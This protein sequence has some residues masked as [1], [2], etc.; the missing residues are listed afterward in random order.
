MV[1]YPLF[2]QGCRYWE[3]SDDCCL[4]LQAII[5]WKWKGQQADIG[6]IGSMKEHEGQALL[7]ELEREEAT[8]GSKA[9]LD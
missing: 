7:P 4:I 3:V 2:I 9:V 8:A 1:W 6:S 5:F